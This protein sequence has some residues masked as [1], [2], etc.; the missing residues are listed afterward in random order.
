LAQLI[1]VNRLHYLIQKQQAR[2]PNWIYKTKLAFCVLILGIGIANVIASG[3][4]ENYRDIDDLFEWNFAFLSNGYYLLTFFL[5][6]ATGF[7]TDF[8]VNTLT[9]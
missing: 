1:L 2:I 8:Q 4:L 6:Q 9:R 3:T 5:W 7:R